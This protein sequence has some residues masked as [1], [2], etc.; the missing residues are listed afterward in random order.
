MIGACQFTSWVMPVPVGAHYRVLAF[1][2]EGP[3][4]SP[5]ELTV[6]RA[7]KCSYHAQ[8]GSEATDSLINSPPRTELEAETSPGRC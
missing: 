6:C 4:A 3:V 1:K 5:R 8:A 2:L 7:T